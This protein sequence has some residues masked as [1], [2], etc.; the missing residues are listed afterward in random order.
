MQLINDL[1]RVLDYTKY[2]IQ[3][4]FALICAGPPYGISNLCHFGF[5][6]LADFFPCLFTH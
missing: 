4:M 3:L 1:F 5:N 6:I 2:L